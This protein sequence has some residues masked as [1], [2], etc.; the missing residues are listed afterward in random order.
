MAD[1]ELRPSAPAL[2]DHA[3]LWRLCT[4]RRPQWIRHL[5][6][7]GAA[8]TSDAEDILSDVAVKISEL[9]DHQ[10]AAINNPQ[11]WLA[12]LL[13][14]RCIDLARK[15][16]R[17]DALLATVTRRF[18]SHDHPEAFVGSEE[19]RVLAEQA[20]LRLSSVQREVFLAR[21]T[22]RL[23]YLQIAT[24]QACS[25]ATARKRYQYARERISHALQRGGM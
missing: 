2:C 18:P 23:S 17:H 8:S 9:V 10:V 13:R 24:I 14:R 16:G 11:A 3:L 5:R 25:V 1:G 20:L 22:S 12:R 15:R 4:E 19:L 21:A 7:W 6:S